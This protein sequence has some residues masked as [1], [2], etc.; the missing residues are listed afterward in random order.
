MDKFGYTLKGKTRI[1]DYGTPANFGCCECKGSYAYYNF[2][3]KEMIC[4]ECHHIRP[5]NGEEK[6]CSKC[7]N[8]YTEFT[9]FDP[10]SCP[11]CNRSFV[12]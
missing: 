4:T 12:D 6:R 5:I 8:V 11:N 1:S 2:K 7:R 3:D 10:S 9:W